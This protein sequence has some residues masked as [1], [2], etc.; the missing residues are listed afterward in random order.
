ME[1]MVAALCF[2]AIVCVLL[3]LAISYVVRKITGVKQGND[4]A[5]FASEAQ[6]HLFGK[7]PTRDERRAMRSNRGER[8]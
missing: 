1:F 6:D 8:R 2:A 5:F 3:S 4:R 7:P